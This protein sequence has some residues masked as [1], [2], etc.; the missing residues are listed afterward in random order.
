MTGYEVRDGGMAS[1]KGL[2]V[3]LEPWASEREMCTLPAELSTHTLMMICISLS[4]VF[5]A[6]FAGQGSRDDRK[7]MA[8]SKGLWVGL[9]P[10]AAAVRT[11]SL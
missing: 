9:E 1:S 7:G 2:Q 6:S 10:L 11:G 5:S 3:R 8:R 4:L